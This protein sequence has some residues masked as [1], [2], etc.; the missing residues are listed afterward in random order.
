MS[1]LDVLIWAGVIFVVAM[2]IIVIV[3]VVVGLFKRMK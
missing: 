2:V 3:G 1:P